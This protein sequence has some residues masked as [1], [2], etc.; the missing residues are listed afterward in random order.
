MEKEAR[1]LFDIILKTATE[2]LHNAKHFSIQLLNEKE[3]SH[4]EVAKLA[5]EI[6]N[7][8]WVIADDFDPMMYTK[9]LEY[10]TLM[11]EMAKA[12]RQFHPK[13]V[14]VSGGNAEELEKELGIKAEVQDKLTIKKKDLAGMSEKMR[15]VLLKS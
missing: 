8:L 10:A 9:A 15:L 13:V 11:K 1:Q 3:P 4:E 5:L 6:A 7:L 14:I 12:I 2:F